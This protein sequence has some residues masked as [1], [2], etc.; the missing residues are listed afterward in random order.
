MKL[1]TNTI[2]VIQ[3]NICGL[4]A[5]LI[6]ILGLFTICSCS[7]TKVIINQNE[8]PDECYSG[9]KKDSTVKTAWNS[10]IPN[11]FTVEL[12]S[13]S[14]VIIDPRDESKIAEVW[15]SNAKQGIKDLCLHCNQTQAKVLIG[16]MRSNPFAAEWVGVNYRP[17]EKEPY[18]DI[19]R[20]Y[21]SSIN[22]Y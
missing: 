4:V 15:Y 6:G 20:T 2:H 19:R 3:M 1:S 8:L 10:N 12:D 13:I 18:C 16:Y 7:T 9:V 22:A 5:I 14:E 11:V 21:G 17:T